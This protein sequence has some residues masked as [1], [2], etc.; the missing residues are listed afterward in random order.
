MY[1]GN[2]V[3]PQAE[4]TTSLMQQRLGGL[5]VRDKIYGNNAVKEIFKLRP[6]V[7]YMGPEN[8]T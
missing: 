2:A 7:R 4:N 6:Y 1:M 3:V 5:R 8:M